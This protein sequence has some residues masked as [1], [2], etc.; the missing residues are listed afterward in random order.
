MLEVPHSRAIFH[1]LSDVGLLCLKLRQGIPR[2]PQ[3]QLF[4]VR[5]EP[6]LGDGLRW[7]ITDHVALFVQLHLLHLWAGHFVKFRRHLVHL[8]SFGLFNR[9]L[10]LQNRFLVLNF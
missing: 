2:L 7:R 4:E 6:S 5:I 1:R 3:I 8:V 10:F 9:R